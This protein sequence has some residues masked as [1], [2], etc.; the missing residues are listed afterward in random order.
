MFCFRVSDYRGS[1]IIWRGDV[2]GLSGDIKWKGKDGN[3]KKASKK[4][5]TNKWLDGWWLNFRIWTWGATRHVR[6]WGWWP[7]EQQGWLFFSEK[8]KIDV[9]RFKTEAN[10]RWLTSQSFRK[11]ISPRRMSQEGNSDWAIR[12]ERP[13]WSENII[14]VKPAVAVNNLKS[15][16]RWGEVMVLVST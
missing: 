7:N 1:S 5:K 14:W 3:D 11:G 12:R 8:L 15:C 9:K 13:N 4:R 16:V 10:V 6:A 2:K